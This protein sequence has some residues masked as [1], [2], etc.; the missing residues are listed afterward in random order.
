M[1]KVFKIIAI[2]ISIIVAIVGVYL[3]FM[4]VT[5]YKPDSVIKISTD[6]NKEDQVKKNTNL[7][8]TTFNIGYCG[9]DKDQDFFMDGGTGSRSESKEKTLENLD[10]IT[11][12]LKKQQDT[13]ILLQEVDK[14][15]TR[16]YN[17]NEYDEIKDSL[18]GYSSTFAT[19]YKVPWVPI[20]LKQPHGRVEAGLAL[21]SNYKINE[22]NRYQFPGEEKW[23]RKLAE[24]DRCFIESR[25]PIEGG[26]EFILINAHLSAYDKGGLLRKMQ[27]EFLMSYL[28][29][30]YEK[31]NYLV[32]GGD[33]NQLIP[34]VKQ[35][36]FN[37]TQSWP[38]W[39]KTVP[40]ELVAENFKWGFDQNVASNRSNEAPFEKGK[41]Y[42]TTI[43]GFLVS[44]N[45]E[46][47]QVKCHDLQFKNSDHNPVTM[48]F[49]L[50]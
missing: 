45:V 34:G 6:N 30:E 35:E 8:V 36:L 15:A 31:G 9:L 10:S 18:S 1:Q 22:A 21:F 47:K 49:S 32:V 17:I 20:P 40:E 44:P 2:A 48:E 16:T 38:E 7:N 29:K 19:N 11:S 41:N 5:D 12:F 13:F 23:P 50:K 3:I 14:K 28:Q 26:K 4:T 39:L 24:L 27:L 25:M 42:I 43:D 46:I 37:N 33:W